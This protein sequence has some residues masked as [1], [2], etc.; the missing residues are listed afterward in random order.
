[1]FT[2]DRPRSHWNVCV[3]VESCTALKRGGTI[4][5]IVYLSGKSCALKMSDLDHRGEIQGGGINSIGL[6]DQQSSTFVPRPAVG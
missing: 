1:M 2:Q 3:L 4:T 5:S 6:L